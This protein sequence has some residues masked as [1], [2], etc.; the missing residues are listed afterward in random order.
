MVSY[1]RQKTYSG[2]LDPT[3]VFSEYSQSPIQVSPQ[4]QASTSEVSRFVFKTIFRQL[5]NYAYR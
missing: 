2:E 4:T 3:F 5:L 1:F